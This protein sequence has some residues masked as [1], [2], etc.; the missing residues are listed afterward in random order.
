MPSS[1]GLL[2]L[3]AEIIHDTLKLL[4]CHMCLFAFACY[5][6]A[7]WVVDVQDAVKV[8]QGF[9]ERGGGALNFSVLALCATT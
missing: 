3:G 2:G 5:L 1:F 4:L 7:L 9:I 8:M 6:K